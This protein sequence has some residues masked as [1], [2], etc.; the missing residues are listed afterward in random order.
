MKLYGGNNHGRHDGG[1]HSSK[2]KTEPAKIHAKKNKKGGKKRL[3]RVLVVI[4]CILAAIALAVLIWWKVTVVPPDLDSLNVPPADTSSPADTVATPTPSETPD[5]EEPADTPE[6]S[7]S[8]GEAVDGQNDGMFTFVVLGDDQGNGNTDTMIVA[9]F[10]TV[11]GKLDAVSIPRDTAVN[12]SWSTKK[13]NTLYHANNGGIE[14]VVTGLESILGFRINCYAVVDISAFEDLV[15]AIGGVYYDV[16]FY[17]NYWDP[18]QNLRI[19][20]PAGYQWLNGENALKVV[21]FRVGSNGT[22]YPDGDIGRIR[23]QQDFLM[24]V[25]KQMLQLKNIP[26]IDEVAEIFVEK[27]DTNLTT[28]NILWFATEFLKLDA[29]D[30]QFHALPANTNDSIRGF[31]YCTIYP[32][33][34]LALVNERL[35]PMNYEITLED[36]DII[37]RDGNGSLYATG[38]QIKGGYESFLNYDDYISSITG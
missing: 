37:A 9:R 10:D 5:V 35:N 23:T 4:L 25:A 32:E 30:I 33:E 17:M 26:N 11:N 18:T 7:E 2:E 28:G 38:G 1:Q 24:S 6:P 12:V 20:I 27:V 34:W 19:D 14:Q 3:A 36:V 22:G 31:S 21:R 16:P 15:N 13:V 8:P 29:E